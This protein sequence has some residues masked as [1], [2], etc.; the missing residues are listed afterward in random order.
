MNGHLFRYRQGATDKLCPSNFQFI[1]E[2][3]R[4]ILQQR[5]GTT[6]TTEKQHQGL[7]EGI[8][9]GS[10]SRRQSGERGR[11][12]FS[13][14]EEI[15]SGTMRRWQEVDDLEKINFVVYLHC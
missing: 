10:V 15:R 11:I 4:V 14:Q 13:A 5:S 6:G 1:P 8:E 3:S 2:S 7:T 9:R 12:V